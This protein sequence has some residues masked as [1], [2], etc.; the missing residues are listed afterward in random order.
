MNYLINLGLG[1]SL[2][3]FLLS[4]C[5]AIEYVSPRGRY[6]LRQRIP[7]TL[8]QV[9]GSTLLISLI[10]PLHML[11]DGLGIGP[12]VTVPLW[13]WLSPLGV[14]GYALQVL[15]ALAL[16]DFLRYW[17]HRA[18]HE[19]FWPI[20]AVHHAPREL[21]AANSIGHPLQAIPEFFFV[22]VP[23]S[24][25]AFDGPGTPIAVNL[26]SSLLTVYIHTASDFHF[27]PLRAA[28]VD[29]RFH[30]IHHSVEAHHIDKNYGICF[31]L[32]DR[33]FGTAYWP[34][35]NEWPEVGIED[36]PPATVRDFLLYPLPHKRPDLIDDYAL[37]IPSTREA[38]EPSLAVL[39][40][41]LIGESDHA[42]TGSDGPTT[43]IS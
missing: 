27:G 5:V 30:R 7:G 39:S 13:S 8:M 11:W 23:L 20:H 1:A 32:W 10:I 43:A 17:R 14:A 2:A 22:A 33:I 4:L 41:S 37:S 9:V 26:V 18:E 12:V 3:L 6:T 28:V 16:L 21:H 25:V 35:P 40:S 15:V 34:R 29:N 31:S 24:F 38:R 36:A 42:A 19:W